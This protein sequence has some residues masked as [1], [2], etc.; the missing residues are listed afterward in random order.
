MKVLSVEGLK[1]LKDSLQKTGKMG[2]RKE[3]KPIISAII[4]ANKGKAIEIS[5]DDIKPH[6]AEGMTEGLL[7]EIADENKVNLILSKP[8]MIKKESKKG[9]ISDVPRYL[10][11]VLEC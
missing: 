4:K 7:M 6:F 10:T 2:S 1:A 11:A 5:V 9:G 3:V 8:V